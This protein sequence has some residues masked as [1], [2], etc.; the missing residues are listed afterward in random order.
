MSN[1][2][3]KNKK[4]KKTMKRNSKK[5]PETLGKNNK[6][7]ENAALAAFAFAYSYNFL[8]KSACI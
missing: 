5:M 7:I 3:T 2:E 1:E 6:Q 4:I 8:L